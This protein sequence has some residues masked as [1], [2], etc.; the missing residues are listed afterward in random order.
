MLISTPTRSARKGPT[1]RRSPA[2]C[3]GTLVLSPRRSTIIAWQSDTRGGKNHGHPRLPGLELITRM[4]GKYLGLDH[5]PWHEEGQT[6]ITV[7]VKAT[8]VTGMRS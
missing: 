7:T 1:Q 5:Y 3:S 8:R 2:S 4:A 6:E